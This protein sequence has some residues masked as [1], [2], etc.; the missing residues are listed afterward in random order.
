MS[1][2]TDLVRP[3]AYFI[4]FVLL[5]VLLG[6]MWRYALWS[7]ASSGLDLIPKEMLA[8]APWLKVLLG[9][10]T[11][12]IVLSLMIVAPLLNLITLFIWSGL[13]HLFLTMFGGAQGG[14]GATIRVV[15]YSQTAGIAVAIPLAGGVIQILWGLILQIIG[16]SQAHRA[17][18]WKAA[19]AVIAPL[20]LCCGCLV[21]LVVISGFAAG[22]LLK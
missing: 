1:L 22:N 8:A 6:Q 9:R 10:P 15:C 2:T 3:I 18:I 14:F 20:V 19:L 21:G 13:V 5:G 16:L 7:Q 12:L 17:E 11:L 4:F